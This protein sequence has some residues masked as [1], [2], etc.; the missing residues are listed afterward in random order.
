MKPIKTLIVDTK[1]SKKLEEFLLKHPE[2]Q[3]IGKTDSIAGTFC[4]IVKNKPDL[5]FIQI[6]K[7]ND[8]DK[9]TLEKAFENETY[10]PKSVIVSN[11]P[12]NCLQKV[13]ISEVYKLQKPLNKCG[14]KPNY[15]TISYRQDKERNFS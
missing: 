1:S 2:I 13:N 14:Y 12:D 11:N 6:D 3:I 15:Q 4:E 10:I 5:I 7:L 9:F 8:K